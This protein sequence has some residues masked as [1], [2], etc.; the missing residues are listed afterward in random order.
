MLLGTATLSS[1]V[2]CKGLS[3]LHLSNFCQGFRSAKGFK[4]ANRQTTPMGLSIPLTMASEYRIEDSSLKTVSVKNATKY[5]PA[6]NPTN[7]ATSINSAVICAR[8]R[9]GATN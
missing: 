9:L 5:G 6:L 3:D 2:S 8:M 7:T 4:P 1:P